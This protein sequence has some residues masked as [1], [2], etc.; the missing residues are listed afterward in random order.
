[1]KIALECLRVAGYDHPCHAPYQ[2]ISVV[3][4]IGQRGRG[5]PTTAL[6]RKK[7]ESC[8]NTN[9]FHWK[10]KINARYIPN[11]PPHE[12]LEIEQ[13]R[14]S[15]HFYTPI[16][17]RYACTCIILPMRSH[18]PIKFSNNWRNQNA[19]RVTLSVNVVSRKSENEY[20]FPSAP[21]FTW[22]RKKYGPIK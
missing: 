15:F 18:F 10:Q 4:A 6:E 14:W 19:L 17:G 21:Q 12:G 20:I 22:T 3:I 11:H 2:S 5:W 16:I 13:A 8:K 1:M 7:K 9:I